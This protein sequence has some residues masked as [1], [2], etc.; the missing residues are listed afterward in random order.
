MTVAPIS[1]GVALA[2]HD[3]KRTTQGFKTYTPSGKIPNP[4][5]SCSVKLYMTPAFMEE[6]P[7]PPEAEVRVEYVKYYST[8]R[9]HCNAQDVYALGIDRRI[10][11]R[12]PS[13]TRPCSRSSCRT[14]TTKRGRTTTPHR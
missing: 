10:T 9:S 8:T 2:T 13:T 1:S 5:E 3:D 11:F 12:A 6:G 14:A 7:I 4:G